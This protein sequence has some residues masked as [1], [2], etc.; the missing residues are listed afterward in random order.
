MTNGVLNRFR[1]FFNRK[2]G[3]GYVCALLSLYTLVAFHYP[4]F[5]YVAE[6]VSSDFSGV[7]LVGS[8]AIVMFALNYL[9]YY[10]LLFCGRVVGKSIVALSLVADAFCFYFITTYNVLI[11]RS[12]MANFYN[13]QYSEASSFLSW[14]MLLYALL[15]GILPAVLLLCKRI[16]YGSIKGFLCNL[17]IAL[18]VILAVVG[19]NYKSTFWIDRHAPVIGSKLMPWSY[20]INS[21]RHFNHQRKAN[22]KEIILPDAEIATDS[23]DICVL[24]I[25]ESARSQNFSLYGY[26]RNTNPLMKAAGVTAI[27]ARASHTN[28]IGAVKA[29]L[30]HTPSRTL[31]E[32]LPNYLSRNGVDVIWRSSNWG[33]PPLHIEKRFSKSALKKL[34]PE[35]DD[36]FDGI[37]FHAL[38]E[39]IAESKSDKV[40]I[41]IHTYTSHGPEYYSNTPDSFKV[42]LPECTTVEMANAKYEELINAYD[43]TVVYTDYLVHSVIEMLKREFPN[44]R[45]CVIFISDHGESLGEG[46]LYM[47]GVP[48]ATAPAE[49]LD[50]PFIVWTSENAATKVKD[51]EEAGHYHIYHSVLHFLGMQTPFYDETKNIFE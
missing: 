14:G 33:T 7:W 9:I 11:D 6:N 38:E 40:F 45:S 13:T 32:V 26:E 8:L 18:A 36:S 43:N 5:D 42:F 1:E 37:L 29:L 46:G 47:H 34:Y 23:K 2:S 16:D 31:Y 4:F 30:Q 41:G 17:G 19:S 49:Q 50:I 12:M 39:Q 35:A 3:L 21:F 48:M 25:G 15:L 51:I 22:Q 28:T 20:T 24:I 44:R 27:K 10:L